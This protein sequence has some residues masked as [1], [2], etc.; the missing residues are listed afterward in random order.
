MVGHIQL[1][2]ITKEQSNCL[3][4]LILIES[5]TSWS[6]IEKYLGAIA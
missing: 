4:S 2:T 5:G 3:V 1:F 6:I